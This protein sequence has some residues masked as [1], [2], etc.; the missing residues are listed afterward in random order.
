MSFYIKTSSKPKLLFISHEASLTGAPILLL[1]LL[2]LLKRSGQF[3]L[4]VLLYRGGDL[5]DKFKHISSVFIL[6]SSEYK[7][8]KNFILRAINFVVYRLR[9]LYFKATMQKPNL[10]FSNTIVNGRLIKAFK[11][12]GIPIVTYIHELESTIQYF[13]KDHISEFAIEYS[14]FFIAPAKIVAANLMK[15]HAVKEDKIF[16]LNYL[17]PYDPNVIL[18]K[19]KTREIFL[20]QFGI[21]SEK[22]CV[23]GMGKATHRKGIDI[24]IE[25]CYQTYQ[26]DKNIH[27]VWIGEIEDEKM[28]KYINNYISDNKINDAIT[29]AG[30]QLYSI[31]SLLPFDIFLLTSREDPYPLVVIEAAIMKI[32]ALCFEGSGGAPEFISDDSGWTVPD[33]SA[34][35]FALKLIDIKNK[36][37]EVKIRGLNAYNKAIALHTNEEFILRQ[38]NLILDKIINP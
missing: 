24:F 35:S 31:S 2:T 36:N 13:K 32:P 10:I 7:N 17:L 26:L 38:F 21:P 28:S 11:K 1:N 18:D 5:E 29:L 22:F 8:V 30:R 37:D 4:E 12:S 19:S 34:K 25:T 9:I 15:N 3:E 27:F 6:K 20:R 33:F 23:V 14:D 16:F